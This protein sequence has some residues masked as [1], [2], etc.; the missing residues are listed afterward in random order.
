M[1]M[2]ARSSKRWTAAEARE[3]NANNPSHWPRYEVIDGELLVTPAPRPVHQ[4]AVEELVLRLGPYVRQQG[5]GHTL[6]AP[7]DIELDQDSTVAPDVFVIPRRP[8]PRPTRWSE[9]TTLLLAIEVIS[10]STARADRVKKR[11]YFGR[12]GV[13]EYWIIDC[14][15]RVIERWRPDDERAL[16]CDTDLI[17]APPSA[18]DPFVLD[19]QAYFGD[20]FGDGM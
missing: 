4:Y 12:N 1:G 15:A 6:T 19:L 13:P 14:D 8:G 10:P 20:V 11:R 2:P 16:V 3:L 17:W 5:I 18:R 7:A 9:I